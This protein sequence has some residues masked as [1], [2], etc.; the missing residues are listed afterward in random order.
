MS[1]RERIAQRVSRPMFKISVAYI[2]IHAFMNIIL[3][4]ITAFAPDE[5]NYL[6]IFSGVVKGDLVFDGFA[7]WPTNNQLFLELIYFPATIFSMFGLT[8]LQSI[9]ILSSLATYLS[10]LMLY[11]LAGETRVMGM[12]Q[13]NWVVLGFFVPS[14][15]LWS[16]LG[17]RESFIFLWLTCIFYFLKKYIDS[18]RLIHG[19]ALLAS[20]ASLALTK[21]YLYAILAI[22]LVIA[23]FFIVLA[24]R[25]FNVSL[26]IILG[27]VLAPIVLL[28]EVRE[29]VSSGVKFVV[30]QK[31]IQQPEVDSS[32]DSSARVNRGETTK[33]FLAEARDNPIFYWIV[34][35]TG[36]Y[37]GIENQAANS[38][39][40]SSSKDLTEVGNKLSITPASLRNPVSLLQGTIGFV[41]KPIPFLDNGSTFLNILSY[42]S[43]FWY[44]I[45]G[46]LA[47]II[48][49]LVRGRIKWNLSSSTAS[50][51][52]L[53]FLIQSAL[54]EINVGTAYRHRSILLLGILI[55]CAVIRDNPISSRRVHVIN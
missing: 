26:L 34:Q 21:N 43:V 35:K 22:S 1:L 3:D 53:G 44:P 37:Q 4:E 25:F 52:I 18:N 19:V 47:S 15:V 32:S 41:M 2:F 12:S 13:R 46:L 49:R 51:F 48:Y 27:M 8:D 6:A 30:E 24:T 20:S 29:S 28:P 36:I 54:M 39:S 55:L 7:G 14:I 42:E 40:G 10:L 50:L 33:N 38:L 23:T 31:I 5:N 9:R 16:S 11:A 45:Y 17:L